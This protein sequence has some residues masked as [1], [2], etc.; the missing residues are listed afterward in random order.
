VTRE[1]ADELAS[2]LSTLE[3]ANRLAEWFIVEEADFKVSQLRELFLLIAQGAERRGAEREREGSIEAEAARSYTPPEL[4]GRCPTCGGVA[5][6]GLMD[7]RFMCEDVTH[8]PW[9]APGKPEE[10][11]LRIGKDGRV[12]RV[13][14]ELERLEKEGK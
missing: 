9:S 12:I 2:N 11:Y 3:D 10:P 5:A 1:D 7:G 8:K 14:E 6:I 4:R 13:R